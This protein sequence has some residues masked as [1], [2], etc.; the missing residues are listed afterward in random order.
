[1]RLT[2]FFLILSAFTG[3]IRAQVQHP[4][5]PKP[6]FDYVSED[7][8]F[9]NGIDNVTL[10]GTFT[11]PKGSGKYPTVI[12][13]S[14]S[15]PQNRN[16]E[17][18][19]QKPFLVIADHLTKNGIAVLRYDDRGTAESTGNMAKADVSDF[20]RDVRAA[21]SYLKKR[22]DVDP[23][24]IGIMG[25][26]EG[27]MIGQ[28]VAAEEPTLAFF[29]SL[30]GPG[31]DGATVIM[32]QAEALNRQMGVNDSVLTINLGLQRKLMNALVEEHNPDMLKARLGKLLQETY[33]SKPELKL[34]VKENIFIEKTRDALMSPEYV[35]LIR[36]DPKK[37][38]PR[39]KCPVLAINGNKDVQ[40]I[41]SINLKGWKEG[42]KNNVTI[43]EKD[44]LNHLFQH[45]KTCTVPE[46]GQLSETISPA[47]L[48]EITAWI[49]QKTGPR[50]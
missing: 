3:S 24:K 4:Q 15:G 8:K 23:K 46:Y 26:S 22:N 17:L 44:G 18:M 19:G 12:L 41:S 32:S 40:V 7:V 21:F 35:S 37:Y 27:G 38:F 2:A 6:P 31:V 30:A 34:A 50:K 47:V 14:G 25:H 49:K 28:I 42:L 48:D 1:M 10:A 36:H 39:I 33:E 29:V 9:V 5:E 43:S 11:R 16:S 13:I 45:C 20:A